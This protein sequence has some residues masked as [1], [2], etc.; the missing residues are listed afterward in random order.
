MLN[1][2]FSFKK[3]HQEILDPTNQQVFYY[4]QLS[5]QQREFIE[6][7]MPGDSTIYQSLF[8]EL[9]S[10]EKTIL[11]DEFFPSTAWVS[12]G[13]LLR[14]SIRQKDGRS[15]KFQ[16]RVLDAY[17]YDDAPMYVISMPDFLDHDQRRNS[18]RLPLESNLAVDVAFTGPD[19]VEY[20]GRMVDISAGGLSLMLDN[21]PACELNYGQLLK[22][23]NFEFAQIN[24]QSDLAVRHLPREQE[25]DTSL[26]IGAE[27]NHLPSNLA[28]DLE[29]TILQLQRER[30]RR[31]EDMRDRLVN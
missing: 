30:L 2:L 11:I 9:D 28:K 23:V 10:D 16:S 21:P 29:L 13:Q 18:F 15:L 31:G 3:N 24:I 1:S 4:L 22:N 25:P 26:R 6:V 17:R 14:L 8:L 12:P 5:Q 19:K 20:C 27:F 7:Q